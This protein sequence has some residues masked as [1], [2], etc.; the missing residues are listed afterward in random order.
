MQ[1]YRENGWRSLELDDFKAVAFL[2][3]GLGSTVCNAILIASIVR[4]EHLRTRHEIQVICALSFADFVE[5][6]A[7][8]IAGLYRS[9]V[10]LANSIDILFTPLQCMSLPHS[11]AWRWSDFAT[12]FMLLAL[13]LDRFISVLFPL[14][15]IAWGPTYPR[16]V[17]GL[18]YIL[19]LLFSLFAWYHPITMKGTM[20]MLCTNVYLSPLFYAIS[21]YMTSCATVL[22]VVLY[23]PVVILIRNQLKLV[24]DKLYT[25]QLDCQRR[26]QLKMTVTVAISSF[27]TLFLDAIPRA[28]GIYGTA[29]MM[30]ETKEQC[31]SAMSILFHLTKVNSMVNLFLYYHRNKAIRE[32][33]QCLFRMRRS[34]TASTPFPQT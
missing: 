23:V 26:A 19:S 34:S 7:T 11:W 29:K 28:I 6:L 25:T 15:Y 2:P 10:I 4:S 8:L 14:R 3:F 12:S 24:S 33:I 13:T 30:H 20:S 1:K 21:K 16:I 32:S 17:I 5:A 18:P 22:S 27:L 31:E 9:A